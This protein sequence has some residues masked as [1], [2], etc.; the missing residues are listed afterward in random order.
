VDDH[1]SAIE[2]IITNGSIGDMYNIASHHFRN[3]Q[4][5]TKLL[6]SYLKKPETLIKY[7]K[8]RPGHDRRYAISN[9]KLK[10]LDWKPLTNF[11]TGLKK[12]VQWYLQNRTWWEKIKY[13]NKEFIKFHDAHYK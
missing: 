13:K 9:A 10:K 1:C 12:T 8:D 4:C 5:V 2:T 6:L 3:N 11:K 7:V